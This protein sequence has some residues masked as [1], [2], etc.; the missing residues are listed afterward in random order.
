MADE[1]ENQVPVKTD[2]VMEGFRETEA[3]RIRISGGMSD[4]VMTQ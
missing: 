4:R 3:E 2:A 1:T